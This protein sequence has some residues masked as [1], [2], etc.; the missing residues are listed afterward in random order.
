MF[1]DAAIEISFRKE[2]HELSKYELPRVHFQVLSAG[3]RGK[4]YQKSDNR[5]EID[6]GE[7]TP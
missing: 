3:W 2:G 7:N 4:D 5:F 6:A 1:V